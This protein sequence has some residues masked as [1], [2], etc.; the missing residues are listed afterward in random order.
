MGTTEIPFL[1]LVTVHRELREELRSAFEVTLDTAGFVGGTVVEEF[2]RDFA[3]FCESR[4]C[5][6][7]AS[8]TDALRFALIAAGVQRGDIAVTTPLTFIATTEAISQAGARPEFVDIDERTY[9]MD[10]ESLRAYLE[11]DCTRELTTGRMICKRTGSPV[12]TII[13]VHLY[14]QMAD[15]DPIL[16]LAARYGLTVVE[17]AC[18]A[19]GAEYFSK[20][21]GRWRKAGSMGRAAAFSFYPG[22]NLGACGEAGAVTTDDAR[23]ARRCQMLRDHG[24]SRKYFHDFEGYNGR[25]D[26]I[27]AG[28]LLVKLR[29]LAKWN[30]QRR[31]RAREY[32]ELFADA[33]ET[34]VRPH[35]PLWSRPVYHLYVVRIAE[36]EPIQKA[37]AAAGIATGVHYPIPIHLAKAYETLGFSPGDFPVAEHAASQVLSL[38]MFPSLSPGQQERVVIRVVESINATTRRTPVSEPTPGDRL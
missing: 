3:E 29:H 2:E 6:G 10:P 12:T 11:T 14:G 18:Q 20:R 17:D 21:E 27:Q 15:M 38:P 31:E 22:K 16:E 4:F 1:D 33:G 25:L 23:V 32:G 37:L 5:V 36:R 7:V 8:G 9:T 13:P 34:V 19:H 28:L 35:V 24:Q 30:E 26:A